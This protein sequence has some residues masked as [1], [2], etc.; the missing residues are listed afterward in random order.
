MDKEKR[1]SERHSV[2]ERRLID[3]KKKKCLTLIAERNER[4]ILMEIKF[5]SIHS[6]K[7]PKHYG[8]QL[9]QPTP[10]LTPTHI[11]HSNI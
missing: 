7:E 2:Q 11:L 5:P 4:D 9:W 3:N 10:I 1:T 6:A 8:K